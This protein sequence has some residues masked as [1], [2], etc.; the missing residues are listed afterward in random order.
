[1]LEQMADMRL[2][3][4]L[5]TNVFSHGHDHGEDSDMIMTLSCNAG[6]RW[7]RG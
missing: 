3:M 5:N 4:E 1:M 6:S 2:V 7:A